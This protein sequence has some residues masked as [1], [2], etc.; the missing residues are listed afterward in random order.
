MNITEQNIRDLIN[1]AINVLGINK[2]LDLTSKYLD[3]DEMLKAKE[4]TT[5]EIAVN[6]SVAG[7]S[8]GIRFALENIEIHEENEV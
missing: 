1:D 2:I 7:F 3:T 8:A 6:Y 5:K 4:L